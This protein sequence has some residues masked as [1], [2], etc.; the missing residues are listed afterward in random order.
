MAK[1]RSEIPFCCYSTQTHQI[2]IFC[3]L[4]L[5]RQE[6]RLDIRKNFVSETEVMQWHNCPGS[7]GGVTVPGSVPEP[8]RCGTEG[9]GQWAQWGGLRLDLGI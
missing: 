1:I 7:W 3:L 6:I 5:G 8:W 4:P 2:P 9:G